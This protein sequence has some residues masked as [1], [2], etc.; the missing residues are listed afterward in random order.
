MVRC[1]AD[2]FG[3]N[4]SDRNDGVIQTTATAVRSNA[5]HRFLVIGL[6]RPA[7]GDLVPVIGVPFKK[8]ADQTLGSVTDVPADL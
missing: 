5:D 8:S 2:S 4:P 1:H 6:L 3:Q 7:I